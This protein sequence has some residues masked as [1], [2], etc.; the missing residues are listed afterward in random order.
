M[1]PSPL[2]PLSTPPNS[3]NQC[4]ID[5]GM[6]NITSGDSVLFLD[7]EILIFAVS[8][9]FFVGC[10]LLAVGEKVDLNSVVPELWEGIRP[11]SCWLKVVH[12][13]AGLV[14]AVSELVPS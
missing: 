5:R 6:R 11:C 3:V 7:I 2:L 9:L 13:E 4:A 1:L 8:E 12:Q 14:Y 10:W